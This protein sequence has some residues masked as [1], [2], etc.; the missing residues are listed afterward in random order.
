MAYRVYE[1]D[2][3]GRIA[4][5]HWIDADDDQSALES[6]RSRFPCAFE[7]WLGGRLVARIDEG[8]SKA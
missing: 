3:A 2:G 4:K 6:A 8:A 5:G 7:L 1:V